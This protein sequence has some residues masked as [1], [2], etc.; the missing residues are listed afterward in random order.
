MPRERPIAGEQGNSL[1]EANS[2]DGKYLLSIRQDDFLDAYSEWFR[3]KRPSAKI[4]L[5]L[6]A[7]E[8]ARLDPE[9]HFILPE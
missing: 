4:K 5:T 3:T 6:A 2:W 1:P 8:L 9:F 7:K